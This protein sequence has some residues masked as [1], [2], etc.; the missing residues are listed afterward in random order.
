M[1]DFKEELIEL[2]PMHG[3]ITILDI[4]EKVEKIPNVYD[5]DSSKRSC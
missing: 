4:F 5:L 3:T 2:A 1:K